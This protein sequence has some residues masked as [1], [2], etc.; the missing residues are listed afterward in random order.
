MKSKSELIIAIGAILSALMMTGWWFNSSISTDTTARFK[1]DAGVGKSPEKAASAPESSTQSQKP[2]EQAQRQAAPPETKP[3]ARNF[4]GIW[5][6]ARSGKRYLIRDIGG[7]L[8]IFEGPDKT[9]VGTGSVFGDKV[10]A[11]FYSTLDEVHGMLTLKSSDDGN[12]LK[13]YFQGVDPVHEGR[14]ELLRA[15]AP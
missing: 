10:Y 13:G 14:V 1:L 9:R 8:E 2:P 12:S 5:V 3:E 15:N 6:S 7:K 11:D 4:T